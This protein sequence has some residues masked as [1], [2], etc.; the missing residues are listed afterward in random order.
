MFAILLKSKNRVQIKTIYGYTHQSSKINITD[1]GT[2]IFMG[3]FQLNES[4]TVAILIEKERK[5]SENRAAY[6]PED[7]FF[8]IFEEMMVLIVAFFLSYKVSLEMFSL[9]TYPFF[10]HGG[11]AYTDP[12]GEK[13]RT[14]YYV[15]HINFLLGHTHPYLTTSI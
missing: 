13:L 10:V 6:L 15:H 14:E 12:E 8:F 5:Y 4:L 7:F 1:S 3:F 9:F 2:K 11:Q